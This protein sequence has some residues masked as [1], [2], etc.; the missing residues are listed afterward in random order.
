MKEL[1]KIVIE[2]IKKSKN[3]NNLVDNNDYVNIARVLKW[4]KKGVPTDYIEIII[5]RKKKEVIK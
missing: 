2:R 4:N 3:I 1:K 5:T